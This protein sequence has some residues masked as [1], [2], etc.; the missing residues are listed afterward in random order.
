MPINRPDR[1]VTAYAVPTISIFFVGVMV[2]LLLH[3]S[4]TLSLAAFAFGGIVVLLGTL[5]IFT[6]FVNTIGLSDKAMALGLPEGSV[7]AIIALSLV[8]LFSILTASTM[9]APKSMIRLGMTQT[10]ITQYLVEN[11]STRLVKITTDKLA[12]PA[13]QGSPAK[14]D[15]S[16]KIVTPE[17]APTPEIPATFY[18]EFQPASG[19]DDFTKQMLTLVGTL[20]TA[21]I[22][23]YFGTAANRAASDPSKGP[24]EVTAI[25]ASRRDIAAGLLSLTVSGTNLN[26][27]RRARLSRPGTGSQPGEERETTNITS[28][29]GQA[30]CIFTPDKAFQEAGEWDLTLIDDITR[31]TTL[32]KALVLTLPPTAQAKATAIVPK[33]PAAAANKDTAIAFTISGSGM[34]GVTKVEAIPNAGGT[35]VTAQNIQKSDTELK[36][37]LALGEGKWLFKITAGTTVSDVPG[38]VTILKPTA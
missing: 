4:D 30:V 26:N 2:F 3:N 27:I 18:A 25:D 31:T 32:K 1:D 12:V 23:F 17:V 8:G 37:S 38:E 34:N 11:P 29:Q 16:G 36:F 13:N 28:N 21:V 19:F 9:Q 10:A 20:M 15:G 14:L 24:P 33:T 7:R 35:T 22:S 5:L 6:T